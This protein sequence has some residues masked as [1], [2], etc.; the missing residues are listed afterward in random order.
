[1]EMNQRRTFSDAMKTEGARR[2]LEDGVSPA[3]VARELG[4]MRQNVDGWV[5]RARAITGEKRSNPL[6]VDERKKLATALREN[7]RLRLE[8]E[9]LKKAA[10]LFARDSQ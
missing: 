2:V 9:I 6:S 1:M 7:D 10:A 4:V 3:Q 8:N 5:K